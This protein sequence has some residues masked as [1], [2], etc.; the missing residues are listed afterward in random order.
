[1]RP[2][3]DGGR[4][5]EDDTRFQNSSKQLSGHHQTHET[6]TTNAAY[7]IWWRKNCWQKVGWKLP[8][9]IAR[10][11]IAIS[12]PLEWKPR[13][14]QEQSLQIGGA[15]QSVSLCCLQVKPRQNRAWN[16]HCPPFRYQNISHLQEVIRRCD[17]KLFTSVTISYEIGWSSKQKIGWKRDVKHKAKTNFTW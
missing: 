11:Y 17:K 5:S 15:R 3:S 10:C 1:M 2:L 6:K 13:A 12:K 9:L 16:T 7:Q 8:S 4:A 14:W